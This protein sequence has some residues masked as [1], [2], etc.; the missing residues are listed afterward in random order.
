MFAAINTFFSGNTTPYTGPIGQALY[1]ASNSSPTRT[2][3]WVCPTGVTSV[4][5]VCVGA[6][7]DS[8]G[9]GGALAYKNNITVVPGTSYT[10]QIGDQDTER[11]YFINTSTVSAGTGSNRTGDGGGD[12]GTGAG[13][14]A[15]GAG[16][17]GYFGSGGNSQTNPASNGNA[18]TGGGGGSGGKSPY[19]A[20]TD[21]YGKGAGGG[22]G[23][24]GIT[25]AV[26]NGE[27]GTYG[28]SFGRG[29]GGG[30]GGGTGGTGNQVLPIQGGTGGSYG[31]CGTGSGE[32]NFG[33]VR[34]I[35]PG[36]LRA[37]PYKN[38]QNF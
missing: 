37:F 24:F 15:S 14:G 27:G 17:G 23:V 20:P 13:A 21:G 2:F 22:V 12:G 9:D 3:T 8:G 38:T 36:N 33:A 6:G 34:I 29:G 16:A 32:A 7:K 31:G 10:V 19:Y 11:S 28:D 4:S 25:G 18:G 1:T 26:V 5:V 35:W 30:S